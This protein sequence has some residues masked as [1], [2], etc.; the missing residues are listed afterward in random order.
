MSSDKNNLLQNHP[1][2][3]RVNKVG[4]QM[5]GSKRAPTVRPSCSLKTSV[6]GRQE[7]KKKEATAGCLRDWSLNFCEQLVCIASC[8]RF[9]AI[10]CGEF[11]RVLDE[12]MEMRSFTMDKTLV[13]PSDKMGY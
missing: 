5:S 6:P 1:F 9:W 8:Y 4:P 13:S 10:F 3:H 7:T 2:G 12:K 11:D